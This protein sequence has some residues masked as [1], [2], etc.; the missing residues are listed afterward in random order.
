MRAGMKAKKGIYAELGA[1]TA[2]MC[3]MSGSVLQAGRRMYIPLPKQPVTG[4]IVGGLM[5][6]DKP[7]TT[8]IG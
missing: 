1:L 8:A 2:R 4:R 3:M 6:A 7:I 5:R